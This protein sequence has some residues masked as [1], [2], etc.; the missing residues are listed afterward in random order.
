MDLLELVILRPGW[1]MS[2]RGDLLYELQLHTFVFRLLV[3]IIF[4]VKVE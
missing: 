2:G 4:L 1:I 3:V